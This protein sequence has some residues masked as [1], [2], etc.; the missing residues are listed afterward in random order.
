MIN[1]KDEVY[2]KLSEALGESS[3]T[4]AYPKDWSE[5]PA[6]QYTE[7]DNKVAEWTDDKETLSYCRYRVDIWHNRSTSETAGK[8]DEAMSS[9]GLKRTQCSDVDDPS[10]LKHKVMRYEMIIDVDTY[11][12]YHS[13]Y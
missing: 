2:R 5:L 13:A 1:V 6:V 9:L 7:E 12:V 10:G 8:V 3:V 11:Q 4:D